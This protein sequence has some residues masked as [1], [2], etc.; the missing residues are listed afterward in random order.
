MCVCVVVVVVCVG[1]G[2]GCEMGDERQGLHAIVDIP[3]VKLAGY[4]VIAALLHPPHPQTTPSS[5]QWSPL[6]QSMEDQWIRPDVLNIVA[7]GGAATNRRYE[8]QCQGI[9]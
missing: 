1:G 5:P 6:G 7:K 2:I 4:A 8:S 9:V 3:D